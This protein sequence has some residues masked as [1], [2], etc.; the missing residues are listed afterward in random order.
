MKSIYQYSVVAI[1]SM[2]LGFAYRFHLPQ[3]KAWILN[4]IQ[5]YSY[6]KLP[7]MI[8]PESVE[9]QLLP[10]RVSLVN[11][12]LFKSK[13]PGLT[14]IREMKIAKIEASPSFSSIFLGEAGLSHIKFSDIDLSYYVPND[15]NENL[16]NKHNHVQSG[17]VLQ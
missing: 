12:K 11:T 1:F 10:P 6:E 9:V 17:S 8:K 5:V 15:L 3:I 14:Q 4:S 16:K 13:N 7:V 2:L